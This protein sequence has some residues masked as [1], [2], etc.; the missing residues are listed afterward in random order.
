MEKRKYEKPELFNTHETRGCVIC[1][2]GSNPTAGCKEGMSAVGCL[3][4]TNAN[5]DGCKN[6]NGATP[7]C[8][9]GGQPWEHHEPPHHH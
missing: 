4:G 6:G 3:V 5:I 9:Y 8:S 1:Q 2:P 7:C